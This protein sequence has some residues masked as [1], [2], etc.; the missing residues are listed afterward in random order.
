MEA[1][2]EEGINVDGFLAPGH[3]SVITGTE[4]Y[5]FIVGNL[6]RKLL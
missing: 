3:V 1:I 5:R 4:M 6:I 2:I